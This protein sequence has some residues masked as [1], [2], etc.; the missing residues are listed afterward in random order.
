MAKRCFQI[1]RKPFKIIEKQIIHE[2]LHRSNFIKQGSNLF[3]IKKFIFIDEIC[4]Y[5]TA[6]MLFHSQRLKVL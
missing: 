5:A 4:V 3:N 2:R 1:L 6:K